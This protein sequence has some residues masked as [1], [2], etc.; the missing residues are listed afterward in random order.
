MK[1]NANQVRLYGIGLAALLFT[2]AAYAFY[3]P[4]TGRWLSRDPIGEEGGLDVY[5]FVGNE[6]T[7]RF[8]RLGLQVHPPRTPGSPEKRDPCAEFEAWYQAEIA[9][10]KKDPNWMKALPNCPC[11]IKVSLRCYY[12][13]GVYPVTRVELD[14]VS[15]DKE[16]GWELDLSAVVEFTR[17]GAA[18]SCI[19]SSP[20][21]TGARQECCY[22]AGGA[23]ITGGPGAGTADRGGLGLG[24]HVEKD[25][26]PAALAAQCDKIKG[27][28][29]CI[30]K[31]LEVRPI[32]NGNKCRKNEPPRR[33]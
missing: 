32:N 31:Y 3:N 22:D 6:P 15:S 17:G 11:T 12:G 18:S 2:Q 21:S 24:D 8:D 9:D 16:A 27:G 1:T 23:L 25:Y 20:S 5:A 19:R 14:E 29:S 4:S 30:R 28:N 33:W 26:S 13:A 10:L 7:S